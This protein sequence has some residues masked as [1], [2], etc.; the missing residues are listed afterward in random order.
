MHYT[1]EYK[2]IL[3]ALPCGIVIYEEGPQGKEL[4]L[5]NAFFKIIGY[6]RKEYQQI[7]NRPFELYVY[8][9]DRSIFT[10]HNSLFTT[11]AMV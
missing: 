1:D 2:R 3:D 7:K 6:T 10:P 4:F 11:A 5:N 8:E 9:D